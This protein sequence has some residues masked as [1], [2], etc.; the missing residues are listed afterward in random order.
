MRVFIYNLRGRYMGGTVIVQALNKESADQI[1][2]TT[3]G[4]TIIA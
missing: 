1:E 3:S 2:S 4:P